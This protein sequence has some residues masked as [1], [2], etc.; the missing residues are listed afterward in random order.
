MKKVLSVV[1]L[2][3]IAAGASAQQANALQESKFFDNWSVGLNVGVATPIAHSAFWGNM[4]PQVGVELTKQITPVFGLGFQGMAGINMQNTYP[5]GGWGTS[6]TAFDITNVSVLGKINLSNLFFGYNGQPRLFEM[7]AVAG[8]GWI[9]KYWHG[10]RP[11]DDNAF[12]TKY[13]L[14]FN[15]NVGEKKAW[16]IALKPAVV[17]DMDDMPRGVAY[18]VNKAYFEFN[19]GAVYHFKNSNGTHYFTKVRAYD[20]AEVDGLNAKINDL[21]SSLRDAKGQVDRANGEIRNL[22]R[23]LNDCRNSK[24]AVSTK[25]NGLE[26]VVSFR[27]GKTV[28]DATQQANIERFASYMKENPD[29]KAVIKGYASPEGGAAVNKRLAQ[30]RADVVKGILVDKYGIDADRISA[31]GQGVGSVFSE[32][33]WNRVSICTLEIK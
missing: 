8:A 18:N 15:F 20:Q 13:G 17:W 6:C 31:E 28:V 3:S 5:Y 16:T 32:P 26:S 12:S 1:L 22:Q 2:G 33:D 25:V 29:A 21:S 11:G 9:H 24:P 27:Q 19:V 30:K 10:N 14:N 7:E 23:Q 4:R